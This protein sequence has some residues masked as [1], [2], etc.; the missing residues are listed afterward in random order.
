MVSRVIWDAEAID[1]C[2]NLTRLRT[3]QPPATHSAW[4]ATVP[5]GW[6]AID[7]EREASFV[8]GWSL[9]PTR[10]HNEH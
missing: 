9:L 2:V 8:H 7:L 1:H 10:A 3:L 4:A 6:H 5:S